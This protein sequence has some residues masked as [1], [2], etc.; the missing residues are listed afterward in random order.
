MDRRSFLKHI[1]G[2]FA[3]ILVPVLNDSES[4]EETKISNKEET[5]ISNV[6]KSD[7]NL[8][9][10]PI[11]RRCG[12]TPNPL[13]VVYFEEFEGDKKNYTRNFIEKKYGRK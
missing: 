3:C 9:T 2:I 5:K 12:S 1:P 4:K 10:I 13:G 7:N 11:C 8:K 6:E